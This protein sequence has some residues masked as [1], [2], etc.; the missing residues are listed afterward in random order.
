MVHVFAVSGGGRSVLRTHTRDIADLF[1]YKDIAA[2]GGGTVRTEAPQ[3]AGEG[4]GTI[5]GNW[6]RASFSVPFDLYQFF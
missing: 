1:T 4:P 6:A 5:D 3:W 2:D